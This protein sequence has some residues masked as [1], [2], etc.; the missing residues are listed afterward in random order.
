[1][2]CLVIVDYDII[3]PLK[4]KKEISTFNVHVFLFGNKDKNI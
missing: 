1:M 4:M 3:L 2:H